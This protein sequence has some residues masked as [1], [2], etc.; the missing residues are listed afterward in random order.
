MG[1]AVPTQPTKILL[2]RNYNKDATIVFFKYKWTYPYMLL[3]NLIKK[4]KYGV[5][6]TDKTYLDS[7]SKK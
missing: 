5:G 4:N 1:L 6:C 7:F 3:I 2:V